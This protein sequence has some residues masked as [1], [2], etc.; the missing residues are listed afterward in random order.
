MSEKTKKQGISIKDAQIAFGVTQQALSKWA[1]S[2]WLVRFP[3]RSIDFETTKANLEKYRDRS[4][5]GKSDRGFEIPPATTTSQ[6]P[7]P[8]GT[9]AT[10]HFNPDDSGPDSVEINEAKR[11]KAVADAKIAE[12]NEQEKRG[13][14]V[15]AEAIRE[16]IVSAVAKFRVAVEGLVVRIPNKAVGLPALEIRKLM[17]AEIESTLNELANDLDT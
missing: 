6:N 11:R 9:P 12:M 13:T 8:A 16:K 7:A 5:G 4:V 1:K 2:G 14:L 10:Q 17:Q 15:S 3:D